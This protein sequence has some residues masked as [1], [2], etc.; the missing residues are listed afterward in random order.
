M[1]QTYPQRLCGTAVKWSWMFW[2]HQFS[3]PYPCIP[4]T[5]NQTLQWQESGSIQLFCFH[6]IKMKRRG[7]L[8]SWSAA[9]Y[10]QRSPAEKPDLLGG[11]ISKHPTSEAARPRSSSAAWAAQRLLSTALS[12][13]KLLVYS[14]CRN[15]YCAPF[16]FPLECS[17]R[18]CLAFQWDVKEVRKKVIST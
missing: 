8:H 16:S 7:C 3:L 17:V 12:W 9:F 13:G 6:L 14:L 2:G 10:L 4:V 11:C 15:L 1:L 18:R 5:I